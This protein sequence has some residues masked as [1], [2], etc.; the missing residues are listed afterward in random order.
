MEWFTIYTTRVYYIH[1]KGL[2]YTQQGLIM[3]YENTH[4][5]CTCTFNGM[6]GTI[7]FQSNTATV[8]FLAIILSRSIYF[9]G[10]SAD[11]NNVRTC[12]T[13]MTPLFIR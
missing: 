6:Y 12:N 3:K 7:F 5:L 13:A 4:I 1:N 2:L 8:F 9:F 11:I 10:K